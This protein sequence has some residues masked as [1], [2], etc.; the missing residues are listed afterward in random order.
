[1]TEEEAEKHFW[2][3]QREGVI[4][5]LELFWEQ[6]RQE[7]KDVARVEDPY[8]DTHAAFLKAQKPCESCGRAYIEHLYL[9]PEEVKEARKHGWSITICSEEWEVFYTFPIRPAFNPCTLQDMED[10]ST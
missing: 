6:S 10:I 5:H 8:E 1:M 7:I 9:F 3:E 2:K 4:E